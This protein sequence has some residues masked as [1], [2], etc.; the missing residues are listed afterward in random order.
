[1]Y[2]SAVLDII[3]DTDTGLCAMLT[4]C[5]V[6]DEIQ[7]PG[8]HYKIFIPAYLCRLKEKFHILGNVFIFLQR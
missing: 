2:N 5:S 6:S 1:M 7:V 8:L 3:S 4:V